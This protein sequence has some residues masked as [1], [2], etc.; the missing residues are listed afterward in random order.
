MRQAPKM[1]ENGTG[2]FPSSRRLLRRGCV[3]GKVII[4]RFQKYRLVGK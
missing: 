2:T 1:S 3:E 4:S